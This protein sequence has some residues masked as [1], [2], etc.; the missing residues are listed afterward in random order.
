MT[1]EQENAMRAEARRCTEEIK[2]ALKAH[3]ET[4]WNVL[5]P[6]IIRKHH[7]KVEPMGVCL[8]RFVS[9]IG[10]LNGRFGGGV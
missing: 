10:R 5:A 8:L 1:P 2:A 7:Q 6:P 9:T 3:P 4:N